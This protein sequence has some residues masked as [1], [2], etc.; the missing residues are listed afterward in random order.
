MGEKEWYFYCLKSHKYSSGF[1][2]KTGYWKATDK[3][4]EIYQ[5]TSKRTVL[6]GMKK[7]LIFLQRKGS[8]WF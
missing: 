3:D 4:R 1:R 2:T 7:T 8:H 6:V 5:V